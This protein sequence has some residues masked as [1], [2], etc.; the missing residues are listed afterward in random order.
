MP[1]KFDLKCFVEIGKLRKLS[2]VLLG[3][4]QKVSEMMPAF[5]K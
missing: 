2:R 4:L 3:I 1:F 5:L